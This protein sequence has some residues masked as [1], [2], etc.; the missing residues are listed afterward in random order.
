[1]PKFSDS[2]KF[3][4]EEGK[5]EDTLDISVEGDDVDIK[6]DVKDDTPPE[7]RFVEPLPAA[8]KEDLEKAD[9]SEDYSHNVKLKF[10]Q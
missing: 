1:M 2:Y 4:D 8:I 7:D 9:D 6:V 10:K 3:P 5:P